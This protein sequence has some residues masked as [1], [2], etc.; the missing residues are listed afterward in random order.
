MHPVPPPAAEGPYTDGRNTV[1]GEPYGYNPPPP[2]S[3][4]TDDLRTNNAA[5]KTLNLPPQAY[6]DAPPAAP[7]AAY[8]Q[9]PMAGNYRCPYCATTFLP[10]IER[11]ISSAGWVTFALLL[12]FIFPL[13]W[14]GLL[15][16]EDQ[17]MCPM[18]RRRVG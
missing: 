15:I 8:Q 9:A 14:I 2:Y 11:K 4:K 16:K 6:V 10:R 13:F 5:R 12:V 3:W 18:C 17:Y 1:P 7:L